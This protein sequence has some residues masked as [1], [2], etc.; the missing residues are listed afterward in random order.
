[1]R[2]IMP[3]ALALCIVI[4]ARSGT[5]YDSTRALARSGSESPWGA[6]QNASLINALDCR[7]SLAMPKQF[8]R[9]RCLNRL[10][11]Q[12]LREPRRRLARHLL[13]RA[14]L[15][16]QV[17]GAGNDHQ[18]FFAMQLVVGLLVE[19]DHDVVVAPAQQQGRGRAR[20]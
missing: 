8:T 3:W 6:I 1:M 20:A 9:A 15:L 4:E 16:Q 12:M 2:F 5:A 19:I 10:C 11:R 13:Q 14:G 18:L 17:G 7:A